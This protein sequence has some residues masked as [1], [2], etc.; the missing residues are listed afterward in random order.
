MFRAVILSISIVLTFVNASAA[1]E[2]DPGWFAFLPG[3]DPFAESAIDL[4]ELN[5]TFAGE[6]GFVSTKGDEFVF[7]ANQQPVRFWAVNGPPHEASADALK[8]TARRLA[9][10][11]VNLCRLHGGVFNDAG[12]ADAKRIEAT[13]ETI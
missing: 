1:S 13:Q 9:K 11:G 3:A 4:R 10:Y 8:T 5:E 12:K 2:S 7:S 6:H